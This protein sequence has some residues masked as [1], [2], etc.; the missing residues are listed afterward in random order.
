MNIT[1][2][3]M[4]RF[5]LLIVL[6]A[7]LWYL[8]DIV[9]IVLAAVVIASSV[10][11]VVRKL[12]RLHVH[13]VVGAVLVYAAIAAALGAF[14]IFFMPVILNDVTAF[15]NSVPH[16]ISLGD[17][18]SPIRE[19][20][21]GSGSLAAHTISL[22]DFVNTVKSFIG[23]GTGADAFQTATF[24]F[25]GFLG[26]ILIVVLSFYLSVQEEGVADFLRIITPVRH[27]ERIVD[28]WHRSQRKIGYWLQGQLILGLVVGVLVYLVLTIIGIP[29]ALVLA[30]FA[31]IFEI[32]PVF[33]PIISSIPAIMVAFSTSGVGTGLLL[34]ALYIV[35]YQFESQLFYPLVV[36][37]IVGISPVVVILAL[38]IGAK[39]AGPLGA[40]IA[41]PLSAA[42]M[43]YVKDVERRRK[44]EGEIGRAHV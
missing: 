35:I 20:G 38:I 15:L 43:E 26:F 39:L 11:P 10:E 36:K 2:G 4:V 16:S 8:S 12:K 31:A 1:T 42:I 32:I 44:V 21:V 30:L 27:Q 37:K 28:L 13:R 29:H 40:L 33:G 25:G 7:A 24:V 5:L 3:T 14:L 9:L 6:L 18:W 17:L 19:L 23:A 34:V 41:V 22:S